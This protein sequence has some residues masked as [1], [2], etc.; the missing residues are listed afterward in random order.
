M[1]NSYSR[2]HLYWVYSEI[3][4]LRQSLPAVS[5]LRQTDDLLR[6]LVFLCHVLVSIPEIGNS[7]MRSQ[8][9]YGAMK[10]RVTFTY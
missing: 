10:M 7:R 3:A 4:I 2:R 6:R 1:C 5:N 8:A 9:F